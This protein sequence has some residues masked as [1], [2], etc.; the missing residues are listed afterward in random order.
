MPT[1]STGPPGRSSTA[2]D[3]TRSRRSCCAPTRRCSS[4]PAECSP[5]GSSGARRS[6]PRIRS[7]PMAPPPRSWPAS[8]PW[9]AT[10]AGRSRCGEP[11]PATL[12][13]TA[14]GPARH[15][16]RRGGVRR[17]G[18]LHARGPPRAQAPPIGSPGRP[19]RLGDHCLR[20]PRDRPWHS[21][22]RLEALEARWRAR[23]SPPAR[24]RDGHGRVRLRAATR[25]SVRARP[26]ARRPARR[27]DALHQSLRKALAGHHAPGRE[28]PNGLNEALVAH[29]LELARER[30][31]PEVSLNYAGL[32]HV[33]RARTPRNPVRRAGRAATVAVLRRHFQMDRLV[34]FNDKFSP[35][36]RPRYLVY[37]SRPALPRAVLRVLQAEGYLPELRRPRRAR[38]AGLDPALAGRRRTRPR[39]AERQRHAGSRRTDERPA[40][41]AGRRGHGPG[42]RLPLLGVLLPAPW[43][44]SRP[45]DQGRPSWTA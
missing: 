28:T 39:R 18:P 42:R 33:L 45:A 34:R 37:E 4:R 35:E 17:S 3:R 1:T 10:A 38:P 31:V 12:R 22:A 11:R 2:T 7:P 21:S 44:H 20:G 43:L 9:P 32:A 27:G 8:C 29:T 19:P 14:A 36:W 30:G 15:L 24:L 16:R 40:D 41:S 13:N 6:S 23:A 5:T 25:R 26:R